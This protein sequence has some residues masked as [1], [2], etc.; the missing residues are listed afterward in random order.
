MTP[1]TAQRRPADPSRRAARITRLAIAVGHVRPPPHAGALA[2]PLDLLLLD[3]REEIV[4]EIA[5]P[6]P[7]TA[8][9]NITPSRYSHAQFD[10]RRAH[11]RGTR[12]ATARLKARLK[13]VNILYSSSTLVTHVRVG[14]LVH[15]PAGIP[16]GCDSRGLGAGAPCCRYISSTEP[17]HRALAREG[18]RDR[19]T[20][21]LGGDGCGASPPRQARGCRRRPA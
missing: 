21:S 18:E 2:T 4:E 3:L 7:P 15:V 17:S 11:E 6:A 14:R 5:G 13:F 12:I 20:D 8:T 9:R 19:P 10:L 1:A 16:A